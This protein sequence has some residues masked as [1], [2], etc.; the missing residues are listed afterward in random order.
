MEDEEQNIH[1]R[2]LSVHRAATE[3]EA[4]NL[5]SFR[6]PQRH[7]LS[8]VYHVPVAVPHAEETRT[9]STV[10]ATAQCVQYGHPLRCANPL[11][12]NSVMPFA[13]AAVPGRHQPHHLRDA[14]EPGLITQ[15]LHL[16]HRPGGAQGRQRRGAALQAAPGGP[17]GL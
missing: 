4:L 13:H 7:G 3:E 2:N 10:G 17:G 11:P 9:S 1:F 5:V 6:Q 15:P 14:H 12:N 16:C 8:H